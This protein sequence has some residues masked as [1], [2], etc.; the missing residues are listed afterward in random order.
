[1]HPTPLGKG[2][3]GHCPPGS[4][5]VRATGSEPEEADRLP[6]AKASAPSQAQRPI[7]WEAG[8]FVTYM[9]FLLLCYSV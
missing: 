5:T 4:P 6:L 2:S 1:M 9:Q 7:G 3:R 8:A